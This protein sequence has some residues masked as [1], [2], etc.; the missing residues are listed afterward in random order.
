[1]NIAKS[2]MKVWNSPLEDANH[3]QEGNK[4]GYVEINFGL[5]KIKKEKN[6]STLFKNVAKTSYRLY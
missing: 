5:P 1:M 2:F 4:G 3:K 6:K